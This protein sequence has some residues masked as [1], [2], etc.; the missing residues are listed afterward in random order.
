[1]F[2]GVVLAIVCIVS[3]FRGG[4][5][6]PPA[7]PAPL[8]RQAEAITIDLDADAEG[9]A[10]KAR[11]A[12]AASGFSAP[13]NKDA[14]LEKIILTSLEEKRFDASCTAAVLIRDDSLRDAL[15]ARIL[16]TAS[17]ECASPGASSPHTACAIRTPRPPP[18]PGS[19]RSGASAMKERN[20]DVLSERGGASVF[21]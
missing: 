17:A 2:C 18:T 20:R 14:N 19:P 12:S 7:V 11:I 8:L 4:K 13:Q 6:A 16:E 9:K 5:A 3:V 15:L 1:M 10:W 21:G